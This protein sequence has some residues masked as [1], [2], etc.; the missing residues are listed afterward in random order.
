MVSRI[1]GSACF[2]LTGFLLL[3]VV[4]ES[5]SYRVLIVPLPQKSHLFSLRLVAEE[6]V[7]R[8][9]Q[10]DFLYNNLLLKTDFL[11]PDNE[12]FQAVPY[13]GKIP[14]IAAPSVSIDEMY[15][16]MMRRFIERESIYT[17]LKM[18]IEVVENECRQL[19]LNSED[20]IKLL[21]NKQFDIAVVDGLF[22]GHCL[23]LLPFR[24]GIPWVTYTEVIEP[25][26][27]PV[28]WLPSFVPSPLS[29]LTERMDF[30][31]RVQNTLTELFMWSGYVYPKEP[32]DII[33]V[34]RQYGAF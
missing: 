20:T 4:L 27:V 2:P 11:P 5:E 10:V 25:R 6:L 9:L 16:S 24:L 19:L 12:R 26:L 22:I 31:Q 13:H 28:P 32:I 33:D 23:Y 15:E 18:A 30:K 29:S 1:T 17:L 34:Y 3:L 8:G 14:E 21:E 7:A